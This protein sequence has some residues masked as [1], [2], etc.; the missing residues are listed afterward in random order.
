MLIKLQ[1]LAAQVV[2]SFVTVLQVHSD[3]LGLL[4]P[5]AVNL[6]CSSRLEEETSAWDFLVLLPWECGFRE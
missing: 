3:L 4:F 2:T 1:T 6:L 5:A